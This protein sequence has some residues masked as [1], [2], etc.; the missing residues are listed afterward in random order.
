MPSKD[1]IEEAVSDIWKAGMGVNALLEKVQERLKGENGDDASMAM[2]QVT[3]QQVK[4]AKQ[5][6]PYKYSF[7]KDE[8]ED[9]D[10]DDDEDENE[11][12]EG[13]GCTSTS[14]ST[15][16]SSKMQVLSEE[17]VQFINN[18]IVE[19]QSH[20]K[21]RRFQEADKISRGLTKMGVIL[22][23]ANKTWSWSHRG[24]H[25]DEGANTESFREQQGET[26]TG[27]HDR[28]DDDGQIKCKYCNRIFQSRNLVFKHLRDVESDCGNRIF[29]L[30]SQLPTAPSTA[31]K[32]EKRNK[33]KANMKIRARART[34]KTTEH[35]DRSSSLWVGDL[36]LLWTRIGGQYKFLRALLRHCLTQDVPQPWVRIVVRKAYRKR[37]EQKKDHGNG[38]SSDDTVENGNEHE[39]RKKD[40]YLGYAIVVFRSKEEAESVMKAM[41]GTK[42]IPRE[43]FRSGELDED[44]L[45][46][47]P[48]FTLKVRECTV[49]CGT[50]GNSSLSLMKKSGEDPPLSEQLRPFTSDE[51]MKRID[52]IKKNIP[53]DDINGGQQTES[54][55]SDNEGGQA[56]SQC[57]K[58]DEIVN[59]AVSLYRSIGPRKEI[60]REGRLVPEHIRNPLLE[61]LKNLC[62]QVPNERKHLNAERYL[63]LPTNVS[64]DRFYGDLRQ[65][66]RD[67]MQWTD[68]SYFYSGIAVTKNFVASPHI[69]DR[70]RSYQYAISLGDF[71]GGELCVE[72]RMYDE[73]SEK[74]E[75]FINVVK[76]RNRI[77]RVEG[78]HIHWVRSWD[79]GDRY[80]LIFYDTTERFAT[81]VIDTGVCV[82]YLQ[83]L[84]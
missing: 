65:A 36:P 66:C 14:T 68:K 10:E 38:T 13:A 34:G 4:A 7:Q 71:E 37:S 40:E 33:A 59:E 72:G 32:T 51:L 49:D 24:K 26:S 25:L 45:L 69:D 28:V 23:D 31:K 17:R 3:K 12:G 64:N 19:R 62:W 78:R 42:V 83:D 41:D 74:F 46:H 70:D 76:T 43:V 16:T 39:A 60:L 79:G 63:T 18:K 84:E 67:L 80:S 11:K 2:V 20:R 6:I 50:S 61:I 82:N 54:R 44:R 15:S 75:D 8:D 73:E 57:R 29:A 30:G 21:S 27:N 58:H 35:V 48:A 52:D 5:L 56:T 81:P 77:A 9:E 22:D 55:A 47:F 1:P 53:R